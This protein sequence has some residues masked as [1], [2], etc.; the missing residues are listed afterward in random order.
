MERHE[1]ARDNASEG[2]TLIPWQLG[3]DK[4]LRW[5]TMFSMISVRWGVKFPNICWSVE[6]QD[7]GID[8]ADVEAQ[9]VPNTQFPLPLEVDRRYNLAVCSDY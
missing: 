4:G 7:N 6:A 1:N 5:A 3:L 9:D 8:Q 2:N